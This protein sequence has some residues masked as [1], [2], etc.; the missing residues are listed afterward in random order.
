MSSF[1]FRSNYETYKKNL[2]YLEVGSVVV[3][4][5]G[6]AQERVPVG[7]LVLGQGQEG[8]QELD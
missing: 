7:E 2:A 3:Q 6:Q 5:Q 8:V 1:C 4:A